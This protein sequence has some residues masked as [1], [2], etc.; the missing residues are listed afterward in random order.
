ML[1]QFQVAIQG[2]S[3]F[4]YSLKFDCMLFI[5]ERISSPLFDV[6][7]YLR[8]MDNELY[9]YTVVLWI[10]RSSKTCKSLHRIRIMKLIGHNNPNFR[11]LK[12]ALNVQHLKQIRV[13]FIGALFCLSSFSTSMIFSYLCC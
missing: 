6:I 9:V 7:A 10:N 12:L 4:N 2:R 8:R 3:S 1:K 5:R 13:L 11:R